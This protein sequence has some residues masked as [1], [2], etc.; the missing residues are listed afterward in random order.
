MATNTSQIPTWT[1]SAELLPYVEHFLSEDQFTVYDTLL[2]VIMSL[3][4]VVGLPGNLLS[5]IYFYSASKQNFSSLIYTIVC[6]VDICTCV[7]HLPVMIALYNSRRPG[8][9]RNTTFC[10]TWQVIFYYVQKMSMFLVMSLSLSRTITLFYL[11]YKIRKKFLIAAY[12]AYT[13]FL[14]V[15]NIIVYIFGRPDHWYGYHKF[16]VYCY[17]DLYRKPFSYIEQLV[18]A[19]CIGLPPAITTISFTLVAYKLLGRSRVASKSK[20]KYQAVVTMAMFTALFLV[21]NF[22]CLLN[23]IVWLIN[24]LLYNQY[25]GPLYSQPFLLY[26]SWVISEVICT[27]LNAALNPILYLSRITDL[28]EWASTKASQRTQNRRLCELPHSAK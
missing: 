6:C 18:R 1:A 12:L 16:D 14:V 2:A 11:R 22:P 23:N 7:I 20:K 17:N 26:Y 15:W 3:C 10:V 4:T 24:K 27:V 21:C 5:L 25:P 8:I 9:F 19:I 28:R 13:T